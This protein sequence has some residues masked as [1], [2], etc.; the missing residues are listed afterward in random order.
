MPRCAKQ[1]TERGIIT[2]DAICKCC[3][4]MRY[5]GLL[6]SN[7]HGT[8]SYRCQVRGDVTG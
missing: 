4:A 2:A 6:Y 7:M 5:V 1:I 8:K 3:A